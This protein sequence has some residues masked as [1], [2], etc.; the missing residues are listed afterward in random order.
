MKV[1]YAKCYHGGV[2]RIHG[3]FPSIEKAT[4]YV[5]EHHQ[6]LR[7]DFYYVTMDTDELPKLQDFECKVCEAITESWD[8]PSK[9]AA[10]GHEVL[11]KLLPIPSLYGLE[12]SAS[13]LD[14]T[15][16]KGFAEVKEASKLEVQMADTRPSE[17]GALQKEIA[18]LKG[19]K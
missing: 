2:E 7:W 12:G 19:K 15:R 5:L 9:C 18:G 11:E 1:T 3:P 13:F 6:S 8:M 17:R 4:A 10:C 14:G 16:R